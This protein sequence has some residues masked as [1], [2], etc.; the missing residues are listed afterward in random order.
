MC[1]T[2]A[3]ADARSIPSSFN[4][5][6][7]KSCCCKQTHI[8]GKSVSFKLHLLRWRA[9][10]NNA[11]KSCSTCGEYDIRVD[12]LLLE[13]RSTNHSTT[14]MRTMNRKTA[15]LQCEICNSTQYSKGIKTRG[16][17][18][19]GREVG[20]L[21]GEK[22]DRKGNIC[23]EWRSAMVRLNNHENAHNYEHSIDL[24]HNFRNPLSNPREMVREG[25]E[26]RVDRR[27][28]RQRFLI[29]LV[30]GTLPCPCVHS[31]PHPLLL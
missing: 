3:T 18:G 26:Q 25:C 24:S 15:A 22:W 16:K 9:F 28:K 29:S 23:V 30:A 8:T 14:N 13:S 7:N 17:R 5:F 2:A 4:I 20:K 19:N 6:S 11:I 10:A 21:T 27:L 31:T 1:S 12:A